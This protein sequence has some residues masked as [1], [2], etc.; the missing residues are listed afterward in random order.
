MSTPF[1]YYLYHKPTQQHYYGIRYSKNCDPSQLWVTYFSSSKVVKKLI[2]EHGADSF[3]W[4]VR[5]T[6]GSAAEALAWEHKVLTRLDA[7]ARADWI[8]RHNGGTKFRS[9]LT[10]NERTRRISSMTHKGKPKSAEQ[11]AKMSASSLKDRERRRAAGWTMPVEDVERRAALK[12]GVPRTP[13]MIAKMRG[14]KKGTKRHY[15]P[16]GSFIMVKP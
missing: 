12:R 13:E 6:F 2:L 3:T 9:P 14:S 7:A 11:K 16:D 5:R 15:L 8:N 10:H 4:E 1:S